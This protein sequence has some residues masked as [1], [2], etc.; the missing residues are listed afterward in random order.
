MRRRY[1]AALGLSLLMAAGMLAWLLSHSPVDISA[2]AAASPGY[3]LTGYDRTLGNPKAPVTLIEYGAPVC[4]HCA[5][6]DARNFPLLKTNYIDSGKVLYVFRVFP[7]RPDDGAAEKLARCMPKENYFEFIE[8]L[9]RNQPKW[10]SAEYPGVPDDHAALLLLARIAG[11][12]SAMAEKCMDDTATDAAINR[13]AEEGEQRYISQVKPISR[14]Q[15]RQIAGSKHRDG[16]RL[17]A[18]LGRQGRG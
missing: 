8:T 6:F 17:D 12:S 16:L 13:V 4:P 14:N 11:M 7:I 10:D 2:G 18:E 9:F 3:S 1:W 5:E 15:R